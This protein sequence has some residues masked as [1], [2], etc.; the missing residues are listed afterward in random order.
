MLTMLG[1]YGK[2]PMNY[3]ELAE[4][5]QAPINLLDLLQISPNLSKALRKISTHVNEKRAKAAKASQEQEAAASRTASPDL[6]SQGSGKKDTKLGGS[7]PDEARLNEAKIPVTL[8]AAQGKVWKRVSLPPGITHESSKLNLIS[9]GLAQGRGRGMPRE[10]GFNLP[11][12][13]EQQSALTTPKDKFHTRGNTSR[14]RDPSL[15]GEPFN[16]KAEA[17]LRTQRSCGN[18]FATDEEMLNYCWTERVIKMYS[19]ISRIRTG[20]YAL[21]EAPSSASSTRDDRNCQYVLEQ[22]A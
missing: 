15:R 10:K 9:P 19:N 7:K 4:R 3:A 22:I 18:P 6:P 8:R 1:R 20:R 14:L 16:L 5:I 13:R 17:A 12:R 2:G 11:G 21:K